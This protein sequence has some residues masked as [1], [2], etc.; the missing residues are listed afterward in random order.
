MKAP[1]VVYEFVIFRYNRIWREVIEMQ[2]RVL[3]GPWEEIASH[4][5]ELAGHRVRVT[6]IDAS[7]VADDGARN[8]VNDV[9]AAYLNRSPEEKAAD[10]A[11]LDAVTTPGRPLP[12]GKTWIDVIWGQWPGD[13][14]DEEINAALEELS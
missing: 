11:S 5:D 6:V 12:P 4:A 13:E 1:P 10:K 9:V 3:E 7:T 8:H 2:A 14:T